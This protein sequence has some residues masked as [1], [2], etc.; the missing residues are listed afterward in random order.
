MVREPARSLMAQA[1]LFYEK[2]PITFI[3]IW[4]VLGFGLV[5]V[6]VAML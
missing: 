4:M 3:L 2:S 5:K 6:I 1:E